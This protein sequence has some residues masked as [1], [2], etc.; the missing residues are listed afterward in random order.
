MAD[1][2]KEV[3]VSEKDLPFHCPMPG[4]PLWSRHPRFILV[5]HNPSFFKKI[6]FGLAALEGVVAQLNGEA[7][8]KA[9][10][11]RRHRKQEYRWRKPPAKKG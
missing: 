3:E 2:R 4:A 6:S 5:P 7:S 8:E 10:S 1:T 9:S 11:W